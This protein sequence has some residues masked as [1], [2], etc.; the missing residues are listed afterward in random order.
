MKM[1]AVRIIQLP[2][3]L[4]KRGNLSIIEELK[5]FLLR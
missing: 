3:V 2:K 5:I 1:D 4:D